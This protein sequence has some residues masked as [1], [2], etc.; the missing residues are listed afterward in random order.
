MTGYLKTISDFTA[1]YGGMEWGGLVW[2]H[3]M[4][5]DD[6]VLN[7]TTGVFYPH[8]GPKLW[9]QLNMERNLFGLIPKR[10]FGPE[11]GWRVITGFPGTLVYGAAEN[12]AIPDSVKPSFLGLYTHPKTML[13]PVSASEIEI[14]TGRRGQAILWKDVVSFMGDVFKKGINQSLFRGTGTLAGI[15]CE[16]L[17][18][19]VS[20]NTELGCAT[21]VAGVAI[22]A[23]DLDIYGVDRDAGASWA[24]ATVLHNAD[25]PRPFTLQLMYDLERTVATRSGIWDEGSLVWIT[26]NDTFSRI[27]TLLQAQ[28]RY[29]ESTFKIDSF[30]GIKT[31]SGQDG[32]FRVLSYNGKPI[33]QSVD[34]NTKGTTIS[35]IYLINTRFLELW[36]DLPPTYTEAGILNGNEILLGILGQKG[37]FRAVFELICMFF[38]AHGKLRDI[39]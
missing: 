17:D 10:P 36:F 15:L 19:V 21:D 18:R 20:A 30:N 37:L 9:V 31:V 22:G 29:I 26:G 32:G 11:N 5:A 23:N 7:S 25:V 24:D 28:Q 1:A 2:S 12:G 27:S 38:G 3:V 4:K 8:Y 34:V 16:S 13:T 35:P 33:I 6:P 39:V 14:Y